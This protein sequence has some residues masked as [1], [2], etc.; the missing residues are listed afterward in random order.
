MTVLNAKAEVGDTSNANIRTNDSYTIN[1][2]QVSFNWPGGETSGPGAGGSASSAAVTTFLLPSG[3][4]MLY[5]LI[6]RSGGTTSLGI[7]L[8]WFEIDL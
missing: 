6:N 4:S 5:R 7:G 2:S 1:G 8:A 3:T